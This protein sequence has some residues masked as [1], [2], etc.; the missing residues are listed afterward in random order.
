MTFN[1]CYLYSCYN[2]LFDTKFTLLTWF[3]TQLYLMTSVVILLNMMKHDEPSG[4]KSRMGTQES[5]ATTSSPDQPPPQLATHSMCVALAAASPQLPRSSL[6]IRRLQPPRCRKFA[7][8]L[9]SHIRNRKLAAALLLTAAHSLRHTLP[10]HLRSPQHACSRSPQHLRSQLQNRRSA[11]ARKGATGMKEDTPS[12]RAAVTRSAVT[13][14]CRLRC[15]RAGRPVKTVH[16][17]S[18]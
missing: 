14:A 16:R 8:A 17:F 10:Q 6:H 5:W 11:L 15:D 4:G 3:S 7:A 12:A 1:Q 13:W 2:L 9:Q 18:T